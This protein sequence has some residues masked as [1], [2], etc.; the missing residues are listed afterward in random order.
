VIQQSAHRRIA[1]LVRSCATVL[2]LVLL[3]F[4]GRAAAMAAETGAAWQGKVEAGLL[5]A[6]DAGDV[7]FLVVLAEQADLEPA[8]HLQGK[9]ARGRF[10]VETLTR[11]AARSQAPLLA[12]L[13][14]ADVPHRSFWLINLLWVRGDDTV[15]EDLARRS[16]VARIRADTP[17]R[18][19]DLHPSA[20]PPAKSPAGIEWNI[21]LVGGPQVWD[22]GDTGQAAVVGGVDTGVD[23]DHPALLNAYRGWNGVTAYHD[24]N[25]HDAIHSGGGICGPDS[26]VPCDDG[27]HGTLTMGVMVGDDGE[28]NRI[29]LAPGARWIGCRCMDEGVGTPATYLECLQWMIAPTDLAGADPDPSLA[30]DVINN[31][32]V[33]PPG[34]G[35]IDPEVL[36]PA[37]EALRLAGI[38]VVAGNGNSGPDCSS[39]R[40]PPA[41]YDDA[42]GVGATDAADE[43]AGF[44]ARGPVTVDGS[45]RRKP[46]ACAPGLEVR[47]SVPPSD[48]GT[49]SGTSL[50]A[51]HAAALVALLVTANPYLRGDVDQLEEIMDQTA[52][53]LTTTEDCGDPPGA[54]PNNV[55]GH[56]RLDALAAYDEARARLVAVPE[57]LP[58]RS[59]PQLLANVPNPFNPTTTIPY[60][61]P[62]RSEVSLAVYDLRGRRVRRLLANRDE[63]AGRHEATW[64]GRDELGRDLPSGIYVCRLEAAG[65]RCARRLA[66][67][68]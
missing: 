68:R 13:A 57:P 66:L 12:D 1:R 9:A 52:V 4:A 42:Y 8:R 15:L 32:W 61:L 25:W 44:S 6:A 28:G 26:P 31:S 5:T 17:F 37:V 63:G 23:W 27:Y 22:R 30:P 56:G 58:V 40:Y 39:C 7:E 20:E 2:L 29:G 3:A 14:A 53:P 19:E 49:A 51:P 24:H 11:L 18:I 21:A 48:Y 43:I 16:D 41:I 35:C 47:S 50:A 65:I 36:R 33:C 67:I 34:E 64:N 55:Y 60:L 59:R 45:L 46:D 38:A 10:V 54:V 62:V